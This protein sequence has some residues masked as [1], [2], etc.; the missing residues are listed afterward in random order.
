MPKRKTKLTPEK[1][2]ELVESYLD[3]EDSIT[4]LAYTAGISRVVLRNW[5]MLCENGGLLTY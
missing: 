3:G 1:R 4:S 2:I 5:I